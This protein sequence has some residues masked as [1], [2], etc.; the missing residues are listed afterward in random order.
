[1]LHVDG[2]PVLPLVA[3][4]RP[5]PTAVGRGWLTQQRGRRTPRWR[6]EID[7]STEVSGQLNMSVRLYAPS[8]NGLIPTLWHIVVHC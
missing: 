2:R 8:G 7:A 4:L 3:R 1:M 5:T 6:F